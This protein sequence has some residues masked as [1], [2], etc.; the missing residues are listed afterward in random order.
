MWLP[1]VLTCLE[2]Q[3]SQNPLSQRLLTFSVQK[4]EKKVGNFFE[5]RE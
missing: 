5:P 3:K 4:E 1:A 2:K